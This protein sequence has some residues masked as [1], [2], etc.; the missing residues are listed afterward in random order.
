[1]KDVNCDYCGKR[2]DEERGEIAHG[3][4]DCYDMP[5][6]NIIDKLRK[7]NEKLKKCVE[8]YADQHTSWEDDKIIPQDR[9]IIDC[10][11]KQGDYVVR[12][13]GKRARQCLKEINN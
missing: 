8:F 5:H 12:A 7:E 4:L 10:K 1:M 3:C 11:N 2:L 13:G 9:D 6:V